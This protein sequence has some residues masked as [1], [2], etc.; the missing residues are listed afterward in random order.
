[1][2]AYDLLGHLVEIGQRVMDIAAIPVP[3]GEG[4]GPYPHVPAVDLHDGDSLVVTAPGGAD[5]A[6]GQRG[7]QLLS[8]DPRRNDPVCARPGVW[9]RQ[10]EPRGLSSDRWVP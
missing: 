2:E 3:P 8:S 9:E 7:D 6:G 10:G 5:T 1:M 4:A